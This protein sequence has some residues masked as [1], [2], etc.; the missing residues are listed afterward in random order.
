MCPDLFVIGNVVSRGNP[1]MEEIL[2][3][4][5]PFA[6]G[7][8]W[9]A[10]N[11]LQGRWVL[12]VAGTH[13]KTTTTAMLTWIMEY[14]GFSPGYLIGG[15]PE[16]F[17]VSARLGT[18]DFFVV[19]ADEYDTAFFDKRSKFVHYKPK[20]LIINNLEFDHADIFADLAAIQT[21]FHHLIRTVSRIGLV[22]SPVGNSAI[23]EVLERGCWAELQRSDCDVEDPC[24]KGNA[25]WSSRALDGS[26]NDFEVWFGGVKQSEV[27]WQLDGRHNVEN[28]LHAIAAARHIGIEPA[29]A[30]EALAQFKSVKRRMEIVGIAGGVTVYDD[31]AHHPT[32][33]ESTLAG[34]RKRVGSE[35]IYAVI[36]PR[37][38]TMKMGVHKHSLRASSDIADAV[39]WYED[40]AVAWSLANEVERDDGSSQVFDNTAG[41]IQAV[42]NSL[43]GITHEAVHIVVMSNGG[44]GGMPLLLLNA[45]KHTSKPGVQKNHEQ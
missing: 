41:L 24:S 9:F 10:D 25:D 7:P 45:V 35:P 26:V 43:A 32:A 14:A 37:S 17:G 3:R 40:Q 11:I 12:G 15:V 20:T 5:L 16:N 33:I 4:G 29:L 6:S 30:C 36:E 8:Q 27:R 18:S 28:A 38:N 21:Q 2:D 31:F 22:I 13:G 1:L 44:F 34:L 39:F 42:T 19:E 23:D